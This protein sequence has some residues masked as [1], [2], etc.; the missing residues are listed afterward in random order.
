MIINKNTNDD[1]SNI[2]NSN[3]DNDDDDDDDDNNPFY[4]MKVFEFRLNFHWNVFLW[5]NWW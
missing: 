5:A 2:N 3:N 4:W 1:N